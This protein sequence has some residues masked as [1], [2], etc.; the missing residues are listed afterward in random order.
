MEH[1][2]NDTDVEKPTYSEKNLHMFISLP[3]PCDLFRPYCQAKFHVLSL[4]R[5]SFVKHKLLHSTHRTKGISVIQF[6][7]T[8]E[9]TPPNHSDILARLPRIPA[10][11]PSLSA[12]S[13][14]HPSS[15]SYDWLEPSTPFPHPVKAS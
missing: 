13:C 5:M 4:L 2:L 9:N 6:I 11:N 3:I 14:P 8:A 15:C 12:H 7:S 10:N 1:W